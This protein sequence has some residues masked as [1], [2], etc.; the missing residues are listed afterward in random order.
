MEKI[1]DYE[2]SIRKTA[3]KSAKC[4]ACGYRRQETYLVHRHGD[5]R[6]LCRECVSC[7]LAIAALME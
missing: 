1:S 3:K 7:L 6:Y 4:S 2:I 5:S